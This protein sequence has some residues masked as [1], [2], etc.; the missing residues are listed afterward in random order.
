MRASIKSS[1]VDRSEWQALGEAGGV[2]SMSMGGIVS[3]LRWSGEDDT[4]SAG[5]KDII[6]KE[7]ER[8]RQLVLMKG[9]RNTLDLPSSYI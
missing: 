3:L 9:G 1:S 2:G 6:F 5:E 7:G 8:G 4:E